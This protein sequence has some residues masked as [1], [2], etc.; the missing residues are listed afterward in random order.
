MQ[1]HD[2]RG[3]NARLGDRSEGMNCHVFLLF[4]YFESGENARFYDCGENAKLSDSGESGNTACDCLNVCPG[5]ST[6]V[7]AHTA[8]RDSLKSI[9]E[10]CVTVCELYPL[11]FH[12]INCRLKL[13]S[14]F[15]FSRA[16]VE[17]VGKFPSK[18]T[19]KL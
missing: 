19:C 17:I 9:L 14:S 5:L 1:V 13:A 2:K 15:T 10:T 7:Q 6:V 8:D 18:F 16:S 3:E 4:W 12:Y 11:S